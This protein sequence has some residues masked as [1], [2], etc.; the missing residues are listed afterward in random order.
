MIARAPVRSHGA[1]TELWALGAHELLSYYR[2]RSLSP[3]EVTQATLARI[4]ALNPRIN[5][6]YFVDAEGALASAR[7]AEARWLRGEPQGLLDGVP[8]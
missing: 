7:A 6:L 3:V 2:S 8:V 1:A 5:A 4:A